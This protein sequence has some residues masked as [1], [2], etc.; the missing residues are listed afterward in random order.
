MRDM[1]QQRRPAIA[2]FLT[3]RVGT[4][5]FVEFCKERGTGESGQLVLAARFS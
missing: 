4:G 2:R 3:S 5:E 1:F